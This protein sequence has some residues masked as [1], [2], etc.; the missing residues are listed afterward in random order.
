MFLRRL[1][2]HLHR[3]LNRQI[4]DSTILLESTTQEIPHPKS[5]DDFTKTFPPL[6]GRVGVNEK[7]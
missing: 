2:G 3:D 5:K 7:F 6:L 4:M 1:G